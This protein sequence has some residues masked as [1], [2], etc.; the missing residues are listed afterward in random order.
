MGLINSNYGFAGLDG[1][2]HL[3]EDCT[4]AASA[5]PL[6]LFTAI[7]IGFGTAFAFVVAALYCVKDFHAV[8]DSP[9]R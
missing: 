7:G 8:V 6:A 9:T 2:V 5:V 3:A 1:A 4:N